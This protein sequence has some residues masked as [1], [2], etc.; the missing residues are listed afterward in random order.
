MLGWDGYHEDE[1]R[2]F[3]AHWGGILS[4]VR[5]PAQDLIVTPPRG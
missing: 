3:R 4:G 5:A 2:S 1:Y